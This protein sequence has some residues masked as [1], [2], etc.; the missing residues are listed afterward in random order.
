MSFLR[1][2]FYARYVSQGRSAGNLLD[3]MT[4]LQNAQHKA[5]DIQSIQQVTMEVNTRY[6][7]EITQKWDRASHVGIG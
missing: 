6:A 5:T 2:V 3:L 7:E 4:L 1:A